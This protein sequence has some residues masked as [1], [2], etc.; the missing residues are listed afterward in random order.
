LEEQP[1]LGRGGVDV[2]VQRPPTGSGG[3]DPVG[4]LFQ[5]LHR[6]AEPIQLGEDQNIALAEG[7]QG[8]VEL[9]AAGQAAA[10]LV[11]AGSA[12]LPPSP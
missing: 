7:I 8:L 11:N 4:D 3:M 5:H 1:A 10:D 2:L 12:A 9:G 6:A